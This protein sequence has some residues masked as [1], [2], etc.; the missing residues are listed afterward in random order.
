MSEDPRLEAR[1]QWL[2]SL[3][4]DD[5]D[6]IARYGEDAWRK[7]TAQ[8]AMNDQP[9]PIQQIR[10]T[11]TEETESEPIETSEEEFNRRENEA[12]LRLEKRKA[13]KEFQELRI[14]NENELQKRRLEAADRK[15]A[16]LKKLEDDAQLD[17]A[18]QKMFV[19]NEM[20]RMEDVQQKLSQLDGFAKDLGETL[21]Q[22]IVLLQSGK[23]RHVLFAFSYDSERN[24]LKFNVSAYKEDYTIEPVKPEQPKKAEEAKQ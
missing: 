5:R 24:L 18:N 8:Q 13:E 4:Q 12:Q 2:R 17:E 3:T 23:A 10:E 7:H 16:V 11:E 15:L 1:R 22:T 20:K 19:E 9:Q 14:K 6:F 21:R